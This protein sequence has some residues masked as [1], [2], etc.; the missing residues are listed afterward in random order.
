MVMARACSSTPYHVHAHTSRECGYCVQL[1][2]PCR[3]VA[4]P[5]IMCMRVRLGGVAIVCDYPH[6]ALVV[7]LFNFK[8]QNCFSLRKYW[9]L[10]AAV[11]L[12]LC[13]F[14]NIIIILFS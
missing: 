7:S 3:L 8:S 4:A 9:L 12:F 1:S 13:N 10:V 2:A 6:P 11:V 14:S 5:L